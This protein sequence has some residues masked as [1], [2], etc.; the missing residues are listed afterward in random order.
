MNKD[1]DAPI[2]DAKDSDAASIDDSKTDD[3]S[4]KIDIDPEITALKATVKDLKD[5]NFKY[6][7]ERRKKE[8]DDRLQ[9]DVI[10]KALLDQGKFEE[11]SKS[12]KE[13]ADALKEKLKDSQKE[14]SE[15]KDIQKRHEALEKTTSDRFKQRWKELSKEQREQMETFY[16]DLESMDPFVK[17]D[18]LE[19]YLTQINANPLGIPGG[20]G[21]GHAQTNNDDYG[22][23]AALKSGSIE[24][25][26]RAKANQIFSV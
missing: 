21:A 10:D 24:N 7:E 1:G 16:P 25:I 5:T 13:E 9:K 3:K 14:Q 8:E 2:S 23:A 20:T 22:M 4:D 19:R 11:L 17:S 15:L 26:A 18:R 12:L 6:R